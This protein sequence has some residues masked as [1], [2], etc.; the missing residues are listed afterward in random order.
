MFVEAGL[1]A[2]DVLDELAL[3]DGA[4]EDVVEHGVVA[5]VLFDEAA[6]GGDFVGVKDGTELARIARAGA[7]GRGHAHVFVAQDDGF[8]AVATAADGAD[9]FEAG[10]GD[11]AILFVIPDVLV[12]GAVDAVVLKEDKLEHAH[13]FRVVGTDVDEDDF[14]FGGDAGEGVVEGFFAVDDF[15]AEVVFD[16]GEVVGVL[17]I[18]VAVDAGVEDGAAVEATFHGAVGGEEG[19]EEDVAADGGVVGFGGDEAMEDGADAA[20]FV[21]GFVGDVNDRFHVKDLA[22]VGAQ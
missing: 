4:R 9:G 12:G 1:G 22:R 3:G 13:F 18:A 5:G 17:G 19:S 15:D 6:H 20:D 21:D 11:A 16:A 10:L 7:E 2:E 14:R 8:V